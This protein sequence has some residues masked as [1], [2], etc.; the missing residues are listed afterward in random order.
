MEDKYK[1]TIAICI[2]GDSQS[3]TFDDCPQFP[4]CY[5]NEKDTEMLKQDIATK[6][7]GNA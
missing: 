3:C 7:Q 1:S 4:V 2:L 5:P 6:E